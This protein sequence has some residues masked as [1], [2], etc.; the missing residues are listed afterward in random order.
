MIKCT[1]RSCA[2]VPVA[3]TCGM[4]EKLEMV[5]GSDP[6]CPEYNCGK[7]SVYNCVFQSQVRNTSL[8]CTASDDLC[9]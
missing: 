4:C 9:L 1:H 7:S 3:P 5:S 2:H 8:I 6:C